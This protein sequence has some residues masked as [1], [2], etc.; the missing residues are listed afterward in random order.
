[1]CLKSILLNMK[2]C[3]IT[4]R[5]SKGCPV[6]EKWGM[7]AVMLGVRFWLASL[8]FASALTKIYTDTAFGF[9]PYFSVSDTTFFLFEEEYGMPFPMITAWAATLVELI[10]PILLVLGFGT[11]LAGLALLV[12]TLVIHFTYQMDDAHYVWMMFS[13]LCIF[14]GAGFFSLDH[15]IRNRCSKCTL[16]K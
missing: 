6:A 5:L 1:M 12:M 13:S 3:P 9:I 8:F 7:G 15:F 10:A 14:Y 16:E 4:S 11:R 2:N